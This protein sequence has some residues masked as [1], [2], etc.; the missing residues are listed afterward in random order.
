LPPR[1]QRI[2][3]KENKIRRARPRILRS[4]AGA[5]QRRDAFGC[6]LRK[7]GERRRSSAHN[8]LGD[9]SD[10]SRRRSAQSFPDEAAIGF[11]FEQKEKSV[12]IARSLRAQSRMDK[13]RIQ[14]PLLI[15]GTF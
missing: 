8:A 7:P 3:K 6:H 12:F 5:F 4:V 9:V 11:T 1:R 14:R 13:A 2:L 15:D 10:M